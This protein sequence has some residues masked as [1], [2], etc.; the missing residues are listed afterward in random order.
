ML[1]NEI[2]INVSSVSFV[3]DMEGSSSSIKID[4]D[5]PNVVVVVPLDAV[6]VMQHDQ[7]QGQQQNQH[8]VASSDPVNGASTT[9]AAL[10][11]EQQQ[12]E[13]MPSLESIAPNVEDAA[14]SDSEDN[15]DEPAIKPKS[16]KTKRKRSNEEKGEDGLPVGVPNPWACENVDEFQFYCC[17]QCDHKCKSKALFLNHAFVNHP[18]VRNY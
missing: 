8:Q 11:P 17:P 2:T 12:P 7:L 14:E 6:N 5:D 15:N 16:R 9:A 3:T 13:V 1:L 10:P 4:M 18:L